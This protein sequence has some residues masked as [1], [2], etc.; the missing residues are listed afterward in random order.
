MQNAAEM[1][2]V[3]NEY[4]ERLRR[5]NQK[6][7]IATLHAGDYHSAWEVKINKRGGEYYEVAGRGSSFDV[8]LRPTNWGYLVAIPNWHRSGIVPEDVNAD[9]IMEYCDIDN[10]ADATTLAV[11]IRYL[12]RKGFAN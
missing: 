12:I 1:A 2:R 9:G 4:F 5:T 3:R 11:A 8:Y 7:H 10:L 6:E